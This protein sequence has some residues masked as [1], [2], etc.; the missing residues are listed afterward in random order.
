MTGTGVTTVGDCRIGY[1]RAGTSGPPVVL[2]HGAGID[3]ATVSWRHAID[4]LSDDYRVYGFDWPEYG[5]STGDVTHTIETYVDVLEGFIETI[6]DDR[7]SLAGISMGGGAAL[8]YALEHPERVE[9]LA[10]IDSYGLGGRLP[11]ALPWKLLSQIPGM[12]EFGKIAASA[13]SDSVRMVLDSLVADSSALP[14]PFV[15]DVR[16]KLMEPGSIQAFKQFQNNELS[17]NG[18]VATNF[19]D[20]LDSLAVPTLLVH[21]KEDPLVPVEWSARAA[22]RIPDAELDLVRNCGHWTPRERPERFNESLRNWLP[23]YRRVPKP[24]YPKAQMPGV[25]RASY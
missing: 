21:G 19:V 18:R 17:F 20:D 13:T 10:L 24:R 14:D 5:R 12:T 1:C 23:D 3:D 25:T 4:A 7:V 9:Q 2:C 11:N 8:G 15:E 16:Q 6:P 22:R